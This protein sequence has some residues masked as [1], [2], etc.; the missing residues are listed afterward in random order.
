MFDGAITTLQA[1]IEKDIPALEGAAAG[2]IAAGVA[3]LEAMIQR[4]LDGYTLEIKLV[5]KAQP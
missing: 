3:S 5:K 2:A 4:L 1:D